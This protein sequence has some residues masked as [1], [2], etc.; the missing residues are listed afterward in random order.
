MVERILSFRQWKGNLDETIVEFIG[1]SVYADSI[2]RERYSEYFH[3][4]CRERQEENVIC[5][6]CGSKMNFVPP[7]EEE[8]E[9]F[10]CSNLECRNTEEVF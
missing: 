9:H 8:R 3:A 5:D 7:D 1:N 2:C 4:I 10:E 6:E